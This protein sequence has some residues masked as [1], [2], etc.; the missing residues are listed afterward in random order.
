MGETHVSFIPLL[1]E[2]ILLW[3]LHSLSACVSISWWYWDGSPCDFKTDSVFDAIDSTRRWDQR[4]WST[5]TLWHHTI[6]A[7]LSAA[8]QWIL[9]VR[10]ASTYLW[11]GGGMVISVTVAFLLAQSTLAFIL[12]HQPAVFTHRTLKSQF[13]HIQMLTLNFW[14]LS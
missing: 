1:K 3:S 5:L 11:G 12:W 13:C 14:W 2:E 10:H 9:S 4:S 6:A 8:H 7:N